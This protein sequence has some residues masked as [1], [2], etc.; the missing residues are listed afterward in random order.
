[1]EHTTPY[2]PLHAW[3][4][5]ARLRTLPLACASILL[6]SG[7][8]AQAGGFQGGV[9]LLSLLASS[10]PTS[11]TAASI[12]WSLSDICMSLFFIAIAIIF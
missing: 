5:A 9:L 8:A 2:R 7:M 3:L 12:A 11:R 10:S 4:L 1:M 6:G